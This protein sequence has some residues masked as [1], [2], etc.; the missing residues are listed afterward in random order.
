MKYCAKGGCE[1]KT[2]GGLPDL[3]GAGSREWVSPLKGPSS[4]RKECPAPMDVC[5]LNV[6]IDKYA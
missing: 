3:S 1:K 2:G 6:R 4:T 5:D